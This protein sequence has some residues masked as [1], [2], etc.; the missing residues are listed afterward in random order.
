[1]IK[2]NKKIKVKGLEKNLNRNV[3]NIDNKDNIKREEQ[4][5]RSIKNETHTKDIG[6]F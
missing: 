3:E 4:N 5:S 6:H 2:K 1:M